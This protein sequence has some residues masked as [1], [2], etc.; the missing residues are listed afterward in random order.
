M[1]LKQLRQ[2][3]VV[4]ETLSFRS[5]AEKLH[6]AQPPLSVS[7]RLLENE[8][9]Q[10]LF[11]R[12]PGGVRLTA[13]GRS[14]LEHARRTLFHAEQFRHAA[15]LAADGQV[16]SLRIN[17]VASSTIK[18]LPRAITHFRSGHPN[19]ELRLLEASTNNTMIAL[20]DGLA[21]AGIVRY[22][23]PPNSSVAL[24][25]LEKNYYI[26][27]LPAAHPKAKKSRL[28]LA[29]LRD[30]PFI[31]PSRMEGSAAYMSTMLACQKAG[32][33]PNIVQEA[34]HAQAIVALVESGLGVALVP[35]NWK[36]LATRAVEFKHLT[37]M[38]EDQIG[39][40]FACRRD[41]EESVLLKNFRSSLILVAENATCR[42][43]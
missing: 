22:P 29:D 15:Q 13:V 43:V 12:S 34:Y 21:D 14:V 42:K 39:L 35:N 9:G 41:E 20:R 6:M 31:F 19:V 8:I 26:A 32:F 4:A 3:L 10:R 18:L 11:D 25:I 23:T 24:T 17:F 16:G 28:R 2:F 37:G 33:I 36:D 38:P 5:A 27:A 30:E 1:N 7:I 40:S